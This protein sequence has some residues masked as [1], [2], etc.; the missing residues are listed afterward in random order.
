M[1]RAL[2]TIAGQIDVVLG[3][4]PRFLARVPP[5]AALVVMLGLLMAWFSI[6]SP[7]FLTVAN[8]RNILIAVSV[9]GILAAP[10]TLLLVGRNF[11]LSVASAAA[12]SGM[13]LA[14]ATRDYGLEIAIVLALLAGLGVGLLNGFLV[15]GV[16]I[17]SIIATLGTLS[18]FRGL[19][20]VMSNG[21]TIRMDQFFGL[22]SGE[23]I[24]VPAPVIVL[25]A[26]VIVFLFVMRSTVF[27][28]TVYAIGG[29][30]EAARLSGI[31]VE[32]FVFLSFALSGLL[33]ALAG[34]I[35]TS[36][37]RAASPIAGEALTLTTVAAVILG[38]TSLAGGRGTIIG[39]VL[40]V[41][42]LGTVNNGLTILNISAF[43]QEVARGIIL[44][45]AVGID[46]IRL[47]LAR[48]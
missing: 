13:I 12:F 30:P 48:R 35:L 31:R 45:L 21:Q 38:G 3:K 37:L 39:T 7:Y 36:Q 2:D 23:V 6:G 24:G 19:T 22:G 16:G 10:L 4:R 46:Q 44:V 20:K 41:L 29:N 33:A 42:I 5:E 26:V 1:G 14:L 8:L 32:R 9:L 11:D 27:G 28:R 17:N 43:W 18:I 34:L 40:G 47:R 25:A 15:A